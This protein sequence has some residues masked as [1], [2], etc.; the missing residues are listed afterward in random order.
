[1]SEKIEEGKGKEKERNGGGESILTATVL[2]RK[3]LTSNSWAW[4]S[5]RRCSFDLSLSPS[6][7]CHPFKNLLFE[8]GSQTSPARERY[9]CKTPPK[10]KAIPLMRLALHLRLCQGTYPTT[11]FQCFP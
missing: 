11:M 3:H 8:I 7:S 2:Q 1:M 10:A 6:S 9:S 4:G 5:E